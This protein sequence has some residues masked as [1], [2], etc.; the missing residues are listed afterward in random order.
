MKAMFGGLALALV[1]AA[2]AAAAQDTPR[3]GGTITVALNAD[4]RSSEP[5][6]N[7][8]GNTDTVMQ[9]VVE[10]L[11]GYREDLTVGP[12]LAESWTVTDDGRTYDFKLR[13]GAVFRNG[14]PVTSAEVKWSWDRRWA[15]DG[16]GE[17][18]WARRHEGRR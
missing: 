10:S 14:K 4:I 16:A 12:A 8:D 17:N 15:T 13:K 9:H 11:V 1:L 3:D 18:R 6:I 2:G 7:R 5:G